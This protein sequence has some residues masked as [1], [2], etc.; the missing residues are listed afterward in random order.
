MQSNSRRRLQPHFFFGNRCSRAVTG[1]KT[2]A[3]IP[4]LSWLPTRFRPMALSSEDGHH[5]PL[6]VAHLE[7]ICV[8]PWNNPNEGPFRMDPARST[9]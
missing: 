8:L 1:G 5:P 9:L 7:G 6:G 2:A 4:L 3:N